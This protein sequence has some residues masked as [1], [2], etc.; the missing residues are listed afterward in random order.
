M[1]RKVLLFLAV[2]ALAAPI[3]AAGPTADAAFATSFESVD[4]AGYADGATIAG[5][6][7]WSVLAGDARIS[8]DNPFEGSQ[9]VELSANTVIDRS[10]SVSSDIV[11]V[12]GWFRGAGSNGTPD[13][14]ATP[15]A[16]AI[17]FFS[18]A[19][20]I[21]ALDG[22]NAGGGTFQ[23]TGD[24]L[25]AATWSKVALRL[26]YTTSTYQIYVDDTQRLMNLGFRDNVGQLNGFQ[27]LAS[28]TSFFDA[29]CV[30]PRTAFDANRDGDVNV[31]DL[32]S[33]VNEI[34]APGSISDVIAAD[35]A[36][37]DLSGAVDALDRGSLENQLLGL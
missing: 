27:N 8:L 17:V 24:S 31:A 28:E 23:N 2:A 14:P 20:G 5:V 29:F 22:D 10:L 19:N 21:Q 18:S 12:Q 26:N 3:P 16:S 32:V 9:S 4:D 37:G 35:N 1:T 25:D 33:I 11:W 6:Q 7:N 30:V 13:F 36:D 15:L 34:G